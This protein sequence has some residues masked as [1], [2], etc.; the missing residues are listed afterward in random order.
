MILHLSLSVHHFYI[1]HFLRL[2]ITISQLNGLTSDSMNNSIQRQPYCSLYW[3][4]VH[5]GIRLG[6]MVP[7]MCL[8]TL[9]TLCAASVP[10]VTNV[11][12]FVVIVVS[13]FVYFFVFFW[14]L[15]L[16]LSCLHCITVILYT[17]YHASATTL[18]GIVQHLGKRG[19]LHAF[20]EWDEKIY[21]NLMPPL[22]WSF[23]KFKNMP[24][25]SLKLTN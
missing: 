25:T 5:A 11:L 18:K 20:Q 3:F 19:Y 2:C 12:M 24:T 13:A 6:C 21:I 1:F 9:C 8:Y 4:T 15:S 23:P 10:A 16:L 17:L 22:A 14:V 7:A